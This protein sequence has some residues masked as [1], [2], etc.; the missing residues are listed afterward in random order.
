MAKLQTKRPRLQ[1][2]TPRLNVLSGRTGSARKNKGQSSTARGY[3]YRWQ[4]ER[5]AF[6]VENPLCAMCSTETVPV[7]AEVV[8]HIMP[9]GGNEKLFWDKNNWQPLCK[10]CHSGAKQRIEQ[11]NRVGGV[12]SPGGN[13]P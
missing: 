7:L 10:R 2:H 6:L 4:K 13:P 12:K 9:H 1:N 5:A 11:Q 8:D 3:G